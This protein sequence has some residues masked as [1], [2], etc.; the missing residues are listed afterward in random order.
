MCLICTAFLFENKI[1]K[2]FFLDNFY[3]HN[4]YNQLRQ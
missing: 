4:F 2:V 3:N 1:K